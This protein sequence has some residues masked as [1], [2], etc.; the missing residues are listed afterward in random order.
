MRVP[1]VKPAAPGLIAV[2]DDDDAVRQALN[3]LLKSV[4]HATLLCA[5][6]E[7][8]LAC[9]RLADIACAVLDVK[10]KGMGGIELQE[11]LRSAGLALPVIFITGHGDAAMQQRAMAGG[12]LAF[13]R[14]PLDVDTLLVH[15]QRAFDGGTTA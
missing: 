13:L 2:V 14:K 8:F 6:A 15:I 10:L 4:G 1:E 5:S 7:E 3:N 9:G 11:R 12:A